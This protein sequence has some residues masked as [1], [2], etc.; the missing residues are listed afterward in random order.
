[1]RISELA[2]ESGTP[3][4]TLRYYEK[5]GLLRPTRSN[6]GYRTYSPEALTHLAFIESAK[7]IGL[8]LDDIGSLLVATNTET[9]TT[10]RDTLLPRLGERLADVERHLAM[11]S[12]LRDR[13]Y[14]ATQRVAG[15][16]DSDQSCRTQCAMA[17]TSDVLK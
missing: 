5:I 4:T 15:C 7:Q 8:S 6:N 16:P 1:M 2:R 17:A 12:A 13:L 11:V 9:C 14:E 3:A 10:V